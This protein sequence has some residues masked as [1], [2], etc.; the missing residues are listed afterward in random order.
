[1]YTRYSLCR[2]ELQGR[3]PDYGVRLEFKVFDLESSPGCQNDNVTIYEGRIS[4]ENIVDVK[5]GSVADDFISKMQNVFVVFN[6]NSNSNGKG[7]HINV[8]GK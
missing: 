6:S 8:G 1:M 4:N 7:F 3:F 5:C 2:Y